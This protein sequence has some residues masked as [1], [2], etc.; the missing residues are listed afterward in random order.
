MNGTEI[1]AI[2]SRFRDGGPDVPAL[3]CRDVLF[4]EAPILCVV[5]KDYIWQFLCGQDHSDEHVYGYDD[6]MVVT[7]KEV[8]TLDH[9]VA[10]VARMNDRHIVTRTSVDDPWV[11]VD[12]RSRWWFLSA[13][14]R[15]SRPV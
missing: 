4:R 10:P 1:L 6:P 12:D 9:S 2:A 11:P 15:A 3:L 7:V 5:R 8:V 14:E 13:S